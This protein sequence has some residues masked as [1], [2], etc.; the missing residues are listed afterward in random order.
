M[1]DVL[2]SSMGPGNPRENHII[3]KSRRDKE[4]LQLGWLGRVPVHID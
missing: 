2:V 1:M 3:A 4:R